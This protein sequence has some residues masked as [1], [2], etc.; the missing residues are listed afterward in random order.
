MD[1][2]SKDSKQACDMLLHERVSLNF[3]N[4]WKI[5]RSQ[6]SESINSCST[7][8]QDEVC[9]ISYVVHYIVHIVCCISF[10]SR[11]YPAG[12]MR[13]LSLSIVIFLVQFNIRHDLSIYVGG[14]LIEIHWYIYIDCT[15]IGRRFLT[16]RFHRSPGSHRSWLQSQS[17]AVSTATPSP[18]Q[19]MYIVYNTN[20]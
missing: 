1:S 5:R 9:R 8:I 12:R 17:W 3:Q 20:W 19:G 16:R 6:D 10:C 18:C 15:W 14:I 13:M 2:F 11:Q 7:W 4:T